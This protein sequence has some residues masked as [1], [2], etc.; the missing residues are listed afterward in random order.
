[1]IQEGGH[2]AMGINCETIE[3]LLEIHKNDKDMESGNR[4]GCI[5]IAGAAKK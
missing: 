5:T 3:K 1:M 4:H 2:Q